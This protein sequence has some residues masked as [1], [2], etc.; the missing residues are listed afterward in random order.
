[1]CTVTASVQNILIPDSRKCPRGLAL[2]LE[3]P[4]VLGKLHSDL[5]AAPQ[6]A[7]A[8]KRNIPSNRTGDCLLL[9]LCCRAFLEHVLAARMSSWWI[10]GL[11]TSLLQVVPPPDRM[12][13][14]ETP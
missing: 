1:M 7:R 4:E 14:L 3:P 11:K 5:T 10:Q 8:R 9:G 2:Q 12:G 13:R 6:C